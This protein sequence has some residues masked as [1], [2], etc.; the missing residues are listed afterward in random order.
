M[1]FSS[2][3][4][5]SDPYTYHPPEENTN[6]FQTTTDQNSDSISSDYDINRDSC[7]N[8][9]LDTSNEKEMF[10]P[11]DYFYK[12]FKIKKNNPYGEDFII[13]RTDHKKYFKTTKKTKR[14]RK[15]KSKKKGEKKKIHSKKDLDNLLTKI[16]AHFLNFL[17][18]LSNDALKTAFGEDTSYNFKKLPYETKKKV[19]NEYF[20]WIKNNTTIKDILQMKISEKFKTFD[21]DA[22]YKT[23]KEIYLLNKAGF[24]GGKLN[25]LV[26]FFNMTY[27]DAFKLY[28]KD[29]EAPLVKIEFE[30]QVIKLTKTESIYYL[31][32]KYDDL[33]WDL[34]NT[35]NNAYF[36]RKGNIIGKGSFDVIKNEI[37]L[38][39]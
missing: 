1:Y 21:K 9:Y 20:H 28:C 17:I 7:N 12:I 8:E 29:I 2:S 33:K 6:L 11:L 3:P 32:K 14:G 4:Q 35:I 25:W 16:Q 34:I 10:I 13:D 23:L 5:L 15:S 24:S 38:N 37:D 19:Q 27:I 39:E 26:K 31:L 22:N 18:N 36:N 30:N